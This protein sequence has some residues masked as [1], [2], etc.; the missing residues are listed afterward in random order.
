MMA[1]G[2]RGGAGPG[3]A[4]YD[5][6]TGCQIFLLFRRGLR[7][8]LLGNPDE[9]ISF[10]EKCISL[11]SEKG[12]HIMNWRTCMHERRLCRSYRICPECLETGYRNKWYGQLL[13]ECL[14]RFGKPEECVPVYRELQKSFRLMM[15]T[16]REVEMLVMSKQYPEA[17]KRL[18]EM[19]KTESLKRWSVVRLR[20]VYEETG[21]RKRDPVD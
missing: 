21:T 6:F 2:L 16:G 5:F 8:R 10:F 1:G 19:G 18:K 12:M 15:I 14:A 20:D 4:R 11:N 7:T 13:I 9:A 3:Y 17:I